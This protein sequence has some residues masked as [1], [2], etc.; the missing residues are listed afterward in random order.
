MKLIKKYLADNEI[1][2][3]IKEEYLTG[4]IGKIVITLERDNVW[5]NGY[6]EEMKWDRTITISQNTYKQYALVEATD[7]SKAKTHIKTGKQKELIQKL[8]GLLR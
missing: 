3:S 2:H 8:E 4:G 6:G 5:V 7:F 1:Q